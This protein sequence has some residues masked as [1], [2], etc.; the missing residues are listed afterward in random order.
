M[1]I[2]FSSKPV[3]SRGF[4]YW[5]QYRDLIASPCHT[6]L[7]FVIMYASSVIA[8]SCLLKHWQKICCLLFSVFLISQAYKVF[9]LTH[10]VEC[11]TLLIKRKSARRLNPNSY[12]G[13]SILH[14]KWETAH[15][16]V[17]QHL[18]WLL[19]SLQPS[20]HLDVLTSKADNRFDSQWKGVCFYR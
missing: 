5:T 3:I 9:G 13:N 19:L 18:S 2:I 17:Y 10:C 4:K 15:Q 8:W 12:C 6:L 7:R 11:N 1:K 16:P 20:N 14:K